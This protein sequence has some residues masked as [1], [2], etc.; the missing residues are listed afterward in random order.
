MKEMYSDIF[1]LNAESEKY[2][3]AY[4]FLFLK[5]LIKRMSFG[6]LTHTVASVY[7]EKKYEKYCI[8][9]FALLC[10]SEYIKRTI[11]MRENKIIILF[12]KKIS[13]LI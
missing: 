2:L 3:F 11:A 1:T 12:G 10:P 6:I 13:F 7:A 8:M 9:G 4:L 5:C